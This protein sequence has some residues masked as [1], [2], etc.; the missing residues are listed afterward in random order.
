MV[1]S[2]KPGKATAAETVTACAGCGLPLKH[3]EA[4]CPKCGRERMSQISFDTRGRL[5]FALLVA[6]LWG[7]LALSH[8]AGWQTVGGFKQLTLIIE[9]GLWGLFFVFVPGDDTC[10]AC[11]RIL[12][13]HAPGAC[14]EC[15]KTF[16]RSDRN[17]HGLARTAFAV[18]TAGIALNAVFFFILC[19]H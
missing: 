5:L 7:T 11:G 17:V 10:C 8:M 13:W 14:P 4:A 12:R 9:A 6:A 18:T 3:E 2:M 1:P 19:L 16:P 15:G